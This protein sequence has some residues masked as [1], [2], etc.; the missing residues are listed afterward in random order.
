MLYDVMMKKYPVL[1]LGFLVV[2]LCLV[3]RAEQGFYRVVSGSN[4]LI[5]AMDRSGQLSWSNAV[6]PE[7]FLIERSVT[8]APAEW[9][10]HVRGLV[11]GAVSAVKVHDFDPPD[12][13]V[14]IPGGMFEM[15][16]VTGET[17]GALPVHTVHLSPFFMRELEVTNEEFREVM[18]WA[19]DQSLVTITN[20]A[21]INTVGSNQVLLPLVVNSGLQEFE[22]T[23]GTFVVEAGRD[24]FPVVYVPWY[25]AVAYC[26]FRSMMDG[27][28]TCYDFAD[29]SCD[30]TK[31]GFRL[32]TEAE[33]ECAAR[34]GYEGLRFPWGDTNVI[35]HSRA[36][37]RSDTNSYPYDVSP[38]TGF[39][40]DYAAYPLHTSPVGVFAPNNYGLYDM[41]GNAWEWVWDRPGKY[42]SST[43][44]NPTGATSREER[45]FRGGSN[46]TTPNK[47]LCAVRFTAS[48]PTDLVVDV[49]F[50]FVMPDHAP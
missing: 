28:E 5:T 24:L 48:P 40:P 47:L 15:G 16:D 19:Y 46:F 27:L 30:F 37:Y 32:P 14:F 2:S 9:A 20:N 38:T 1:I 8:L 11:T 39:H 18:Q 6:S 25:G 13:M 35:T 44:Y 49:G 17:V 43:Q 29:W 23:N 3:A 7:E 34:G 41:A 10:P 12:G 50:R 26:Q 42:S 22:F 33:W 21:V 31:A 45:V 4:T 36:N